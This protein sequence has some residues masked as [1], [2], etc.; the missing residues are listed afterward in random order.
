MGESYEVELHGNGRFCLASAIFLW[1]SFFS[2]RAAVPT[3]ASRTTPRTRRRHKRSRQI[4]GAFERCVMRRLA[5]QPLEL[6]L[7]RGVVRGGTPSKERGG[8]RREE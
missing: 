2:S 4:G 6:E 7:E 3:T 5:L 1:P 8:R